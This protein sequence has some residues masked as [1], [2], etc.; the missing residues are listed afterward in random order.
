MIIDRVFMSIKKRLRQN[1]PKPFSCAVKRVLANIESIDR[2][3]RA[4]APLR[5][6]RRVVE[7]SVNPVKTGSRIG[8]ARAIN[9]QIGARIAVIIALCRQIRA[10]AESLRAGRAGRALQN[11]PD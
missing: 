10:S 7:T 2:E 6:L 9:R 1:L 8:R 3:I 4:D 11:P 5:S